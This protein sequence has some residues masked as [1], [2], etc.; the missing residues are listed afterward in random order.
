MEKEGRR[1]SRTRRS[2]S[3]KRNGL[4]EKGTPRLTHLQHGR[5][6]QKGFISIK[7][8]LFMLPYDKYLYVFSNVW[9]C[10]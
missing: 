5:R 7:C 10:A 1:W 6:V 9:Q 2:K 8:K 3:R 4:G